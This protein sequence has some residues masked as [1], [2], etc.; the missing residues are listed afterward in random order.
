[1]IQTS[2]LAQGMVA[3]LASTHK[4]AST[5]HPGVPSDLSCLSIALC[6]AKELPKGLSFWGQKTKIP[7]CWT[8]PFY[9]PHSRARGATWESHCHVL[10]SIC[11]WH[12]WLWKEQETSK[13]GQET[14]ERR[15][16]RMSLIPNLAME[17][18]T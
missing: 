5:S 7:S 1:M 2:L 8:S 17:Q 12:I 15:N 11:P 9:L 3:E 10:P 14:T 4:S 18:N 6:L 13:Q 16:H